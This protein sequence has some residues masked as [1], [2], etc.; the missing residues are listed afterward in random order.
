ML[1]RN[2][3]HDTSS[4]S[5]ISTG[6]HYKANIMQDVAFY[7]MYVLDQIFKDF[8]KGRKVSTVE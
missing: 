8:S 6:F 7:N 3:I 2:L 4:S 1:R 5:K